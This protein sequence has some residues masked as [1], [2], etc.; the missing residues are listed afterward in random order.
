MKTLKSPTAHRGRDA[1]EELRR[2]QHRF[3]PISRRYDRPIKL[4]RLLRKAS[5]P[6]M[7]A[8][9]AVM[10]YLGLTTQFPGLQTMAREHRTFYRNCDAAR[11]AGV[12]P[13]RIG[14]P[15]YRPQLDHD[16]DGW[17]CE[18]WPRR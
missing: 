4:R 2:L 18:P 17:A 11:A 12:A 15:G 6:V 9:A 8:I 5:V 16:R 3:R 10:L 13:I 1:E 7:A 14:E